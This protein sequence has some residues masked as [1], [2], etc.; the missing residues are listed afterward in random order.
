MIVNDKDPDAEAR[1][2]DYWEW[3]QN[4]KKHYRDDAGVQQDNAQSIRRHYIISF[5]YGAII[6]PLVA[7][8]VILANN[9][10]G[11]I[12]LL[13]N[14]TFQLICM[15]SFLLVFPVLV[16]VFR[17]PDIWVE[18]AVKDMKYADPPRNNRAM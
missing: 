4:R 13:F 9:A 5:L 8:V 1:A 11:F 10:I 2:E 7:M 12:E 17:P 18:K 14:Q 15:M 16:I 3:L 6:G